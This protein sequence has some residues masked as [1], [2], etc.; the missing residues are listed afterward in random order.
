[1]VFPTSSTACVLLSG[2]AE[3][4]SALRSPA[5]GDELQ[6][7]SKLH[8]VHLSMRSSAYLRSCSSWMDT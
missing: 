5:Q 4:F 8:K 1:M 7:L 6:L 2:Q 3:V